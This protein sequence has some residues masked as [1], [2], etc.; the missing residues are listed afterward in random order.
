MR[1]VE[2]R[3]RKL[4]TGAGL[5]EKAGVSRDTV[6]GIEEGRTVPSFATVRKLCAALEVEP[7]EIEEFQAAIDR[8]SKKRTR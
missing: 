6:Y 8:I 3:A 2:A 4:L 5:A 1:L 7:T